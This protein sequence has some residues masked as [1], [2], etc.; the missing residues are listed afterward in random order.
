M[1]LLLLYVGAALAVSFLCSLLEA[2]LLSARRGEL[3]ERKER[4]ER[5]A[6]L[7]LQLK[8]E[9]IDDAIGAI[10]TLNTIAHTIGAALAGAQ[11]A[12]VFGDA[13]VGLFSAVLTLLVLVFT[14][15]IPKTLGTVHASRLVGFVA[16]TTRFLI[17]VLKPALLLTRLLTRLLVPG[18]RAAHIS[19][20]EIAAIAASAAREGSLP[21]TV[22]QRIAN[23]LHLRDI[24]IHEVMT[25]RTAAVMLP[26]RTTV[27]ELL[28]H[29]EARNFSRI[30]IYDQAIDDV[31]HYVLVREVLIAIIEGIGRDT[32]LARFARPA[33]VLPETASVESAF[34]QL[35]ERHEHLAIV[36]DE[37]GG[38]DG[39]LTMEDLLETA[40]G[41]EIVDESD[42]VADLRQEARRIHRKRLEL[43]SR[44]D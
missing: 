37:H 34:K 27:A 22:S 36:V 17:A 23:I 15:I 38:V 35:V 11:A 1:N 19:R 42:R 8:G 14:E 41:V 32:P 40:F 21:L 4:G 7:L 31:E 20:A 16:Y 43:A 26:G 6:A 2:T 12:W 25:P 29:K 44:H 13:W 5:G 39:L 18:S 10:L 30:P 33:L 28:E 9:G 24:G 3:V